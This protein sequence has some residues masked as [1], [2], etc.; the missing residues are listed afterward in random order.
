[1]PAPI[2]P[3]FIETV[4]HDVYETIDPRT[5]LVN[6]AQGKTV[7]ITGAG[8][9]IGRAIAIAFAHAGA[10]RLILTARTA[11]Q[12]EEVANEI[13]A[14]ANNIEVIN[15]ATDVANESQVEALFHGIKGVVD[16][17]VNNA[18]YIEHNNPLGE[19]DTK[20]WWSIWETN[21][22][23]TYLP[24]TYFL[25]NY[26]GAGTII[27]TSSIGSIVTTPGYSAYQPTKTAINRI[28]DFIHVE[29]P[30]VRVFSYHPG[31][32]QTEL[33]KRLP[34]NMFVL[35]DKPELAAGYCVWLTTDEA[36]FLRGRYSDCTWD[37][38]ELLKN[39]KMIVDMDLLKE[40]VKMG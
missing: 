32:V 17:L 34:D 6:K 8:R 24:T 15:V 5:T 28:T 12:L 29:Y 21:V 33:A 26:K 14:I 1:M 25:K 7:L 13:K 37:V 18:G 38:T 16:I 23:G 20:E 10:S 3:S 35:E 22:K 27:N 4:R 30:N 31:G 2:K 9:G 40:E 39:A 19:A 36:D 11:S